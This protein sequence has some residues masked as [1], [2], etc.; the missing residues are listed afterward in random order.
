[1]N[2]LLNYN[3]KTKFLGN[4][5]AVMFFFGIA[6][7]VYHYA[8]SHTGDGYTEILNHEVLIASD[9]RGATISMLSARRSEKDF[10]LRMDMKYPPK[11]EKHVSEMIGFL[12][13]IGEVS[14]QAKLNELTRISTLAIQKSRDYLAS[15][16]KVVEGNKIKGL[17]QKSGLQGDF[18]AAAH[19]IAG[20]VPEHAVDNL[21]VDLLQMRRYEKD[22]MRTKSDKYRTKLITAMDTYKT[23][24]EASGCEKVAK[25]SQLAALAV[26]RAA[27]DQIL[28]GR[29]LEEEHAYY[30]KVRGAAAKLETALNSVLV[31]R[32]EALALDIRKNEKDYLL[33]GED[34]YVEKTLGSITALYT[35]FKQ[36]SASPEHAVDIE[37]DLKAYKKA[38]VGLVESDQLIAGYVKEMRAA[39]HA[40]EPLLVKIEELSVKAQVAEATALDV[41][42]ADYSITAVSIGIIAL[43]IGLLLSVLITNAITTPLKAAAVTAKNMADGDLREDVV[44]EGSDETGQMLAAMREMIF[45]LRDVV[46]GVNDAVDNVA[47]G[48]EELSSTSGTLS[49]GTTEQAASIEELSTA[50]EQVTASISQNAVNSQETSQIASQSAQKASESGEAVTQ[51]VSA[52]KE[53]AEKISIIEEIARQTNLLALNAAIEAARAGEH[54]KGFAVVA[55]EVRKLAER[56]GAAAN[57]ISGLSTSTV[58]VADKAL[59]MLDELVPDIEK[60]SELIAEINASCEEQDEAI[61]QISNAVNQ[62]EVTTHS[63]AAAS[64]EMASTSEELAAQGSSLRQMMSYF[65]CGERKALGSAVATSKPALAGITRGALSASQGEDDSFERF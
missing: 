55:A 48:S 25:D 4:I 7:G 33:R 54:G 35:A 14:K 20:K 30:Q 23:N 47:A 5:V 64:E 11:V 56:S 32:V 37:K 60:T 62:V 53:I 38:F 61:K 15:F 24:L 1:M 58:E 2:F 9:A 21:L 49:Q 19:T 52:M 46:Y 43:V 36:S 34:K 45:R 44:A 18:R 22:Y 59:T 12:E 3:I 39:T 6:L 29:S 13:N 17:D 42:A 63:S 16:M 26:Y 27:A 50:I 28:Q 51:A 41:A 40:I 10:L 8:L 57:E 31:P 65:N